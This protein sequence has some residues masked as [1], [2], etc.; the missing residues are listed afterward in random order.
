MDSQKNVWLRGQGGG[1]K[2]EAKSGGKGS[3]NPYVVSDP[4]EIPSGHRNVGSL[5]ICED[6]STCWILRFFLKEA[7]WKN[8]LSIKEWSQCLKFSV[9][10]LFV[11]SGLMCLIVPKSLWFC[12]CF[13]LIL[14]LLLL[15]SWCL[16]FAKVWPFWRNQTPSINPQP[17]RYSC[18]PFLIGS[19]SAPF[20]CGY[21]FPG[22]SFCQKV[23]VRKSQARKHVCHKVL[24]ARLV[25]GNHSVKFK[26]SWTHGS[27]WDV[28]P[29]CLFLDLF[30][31]VIF[32]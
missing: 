19:F 14:F 27:C 9:L 8:K 32:F 3:G 12:T 5:Q 25:H 16:W 18:W 2:L 22:G 13:E 20:F 29:E 6:E 10:F 7:L 11:F 17:S 24:G 30:L 26:S 1:A 28:G 4:M 15:S 21:A 23:R 31:L